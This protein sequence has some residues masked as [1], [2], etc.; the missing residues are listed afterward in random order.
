ML[1]IQGGPKNKPNPNPNRLH[2][3]HIVIFHSDVFVPLYVAYRKNVKAF[4]H[5]KPLKSE[6]WLHTNSAVDT[7]KSNFGYRCSNAI[8]R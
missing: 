7:S 4:W 6:W 3:D 8:T 2:F 1:L 5:R